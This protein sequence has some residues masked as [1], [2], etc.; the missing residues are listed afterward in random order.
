MGST[1]AVRNVAMR[2]ATTQCPAAVVMATIASAIIC[3][4]FRSK[5]WPAVKKKLMTSRKTAISNPARF[6]VDSNGETIEPASELAFARS[7]PRNTRNTFGATDALKK[8]AAPSHIP[9]N[10]SPRILIILTVV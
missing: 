10:N 3:V 5:L 1:I 9:N 4:S 2:A 7:A 8:T 6:R